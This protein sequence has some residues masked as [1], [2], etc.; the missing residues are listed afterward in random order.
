MILR[1]RSLALHGHPEFTLVFREGRPLADPLLR[2][3]EGYL[4]AAVASGASFTPGEEVAIGSGTLVVG[5]RDDGTLSL[6]EEL[7][8]GR[9]AEHVDT[10]LLSTWQHRAVADG[11]GLGEALSFAD[12]TQHALVADCARGG[13]A[14]L[15]ERHPTDDDDLSGHLLRCAEDHE[16]G[17]E[18]RVPLSELLRDPDV[19][20]WLALPVGVR[21]LLP[22]DPSRFRVW[23]GAEELSVVPGSWLAS[24]R[25]R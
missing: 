19:G 23:R 16:H 1:T 14:R 10:T 17:V 7:P 5:L 2:W 6:A 24:Q 4:T 11:L 22:P 25:T 15:L 8:D 12:P 21:V 3:L 18:R 13:E 20:R 9:W